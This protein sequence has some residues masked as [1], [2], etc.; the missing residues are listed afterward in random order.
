MAVP[1]RAERDDTSIQ[2]HTTITASLSRHVL[3]HETKQQPFST[4]SKN[5]LGLSSQ[6]S[7]SSAS[8]P[9]NGN[10]RSQMSTQDQWKM[11][12]TRDFVAGRH[13]YSVVAVGGRVGGA[14]ERATEI[15]DVLRAVDGLVGKLAFVGGDAMAE[16]R[17]KGDGNSVSGTSSEREKHSMRQVLQFVGGWDSHKASGSTRTSGSSRRT[18]RTR[19]G[20]ARLC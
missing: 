4:K 18:S 11:D 9:R 15:D 10:H 16:G 7:N 3:G 5:A 8:E 12:A 6:H 14:Y 13:G 2:G 1:H 17:E 19:S 20:K